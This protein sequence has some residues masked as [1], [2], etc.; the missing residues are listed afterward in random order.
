VIAVAKGQ[1]EVQKELCV[2]AGFRDWWVMS[3]RKLQMDKTF[4]RSVH[5][6]R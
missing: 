4:L 2:A 1:E 3:R 6:Q 5:M